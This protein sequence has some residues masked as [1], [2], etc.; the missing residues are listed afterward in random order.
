MKRVVITLIS[1]IGPLMA[2]A[3]KDQYGYCADNMNDN[4]LPLLN[5]T[6]D[7]DSINK[8]S[9][10][11]GTVELAVYNSR[12]VYSLYNCLVKYRGTTAN[13]FKKKS[14]A[15]KL[16]DHKGNDLDIS[17]LG[18][19]KND[20]WIL[21]AMAIDRIRM[22]NRVCFDIWNRISR[23]P[24]DTQFGNRNGIEG[25][26]VEV[27]FNSDYYGLFC[28][29]DKI[30]RELLGLKKIRTDENGNQTVRGLI[31][32]GIS[33]SNSSI[34]LKDYDNERTDSVIWNSW[35][36]QYPDEYP[37]DEAWLPLMNLI[38][39]CNKTS[40][41]EFRSGY[42]SYFY[43][44]NLIDFV[45][46]NM[47]LNVGDNVYKNTFLSTVDIT[48]GHRYLITPWDMDQ[49]LYGYW[50]G[51]YNSK[52]GD[53][54][55][56]IYIAPFDRLIYNNID[57]FSDKLEDRWKEL[58]RTI[59]DPDSISAVL[60]AY[61]N[62]FMQSGAW[63]REFAKWDENPVPIQESV[64]DELKM[65]MDWYLLNYCNLC[66]YFDAELPEG[67][68]NS[69]LYYKPSGVYSIDGRKLNDVKI[70]SVI[71]PGVYMIDGQLMIIR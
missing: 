48:A 31:Y 55:R 1:L 27:F 69:Y 28:L 62:R 5:I 36:L 21:D 37:S 61:G 18:M 68:A 35:E 12:T 63:E 66:F 43:P 17:L 6:V 51:T 44:E 56:F 41:Q 26:F 54:E 52:M 14:F 50:D 34:F 33:W 42:S 49:S 58:Y 40:A 7:F 47:A 67:I 29:T 65:V 25:E 60:Y 71:K 9:F 70:P 23:T 30:D 10:V 15:L 3:Q 11:Q 46:F 16:V 45:V 2:F 20:S 19:R 64:L 4:S 8:N 53:I 13:R 59:F 22:R 32:K 38:N 39:F 57:D 24:Y